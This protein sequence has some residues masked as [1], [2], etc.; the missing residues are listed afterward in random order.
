MTIL[1]LIFTVIYCL[2]VLFV[3][4]VFIK[5]QPLPPISVPRTISVVI[6]ARNE[7]SR[8]TATLQSL[9]KIN[10]PKDKYEIICVDDAST[11]KTAMLIE[12][13]ASL[14]NNWHLLKVS[15]KNGLKK[16]KKAAL[17]KG[18]EKAV[19]EIIL[20]TD[21]D[22]TVSENWLL[23]MNNCFDEKTNMVLG[24]S[25]LVK[26]KSW[27]NKLLRFDNLFSGIMVAAPALLGFPMSSIGRNIAYRK[28]TFN[29]IGGYKT[30]AHHKSGDDV[31]LTELFRKKVE[32]KTKFCF[33]KDSF[34]FS[35]IP[36]TFKEIF[37]QQIRKNSKLFKKSF[38]S[39]ALT[40][41]LLSYH[42]LLIIF[43]F[44][45]GISNF[46]ILLLA[47]KLGIEFTVLSISA[48]RFSE[49]RIIPLL[50][51]FQILYPAYV[52]LLAF[53]GIFQLYEWKK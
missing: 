28:S 25:V 6:A 15:Q 24:H 33:R 30:L 36:D 34:T 22:C 23:E 12:Q 52:S 40:L 31:H 9:Q 46:W 44:L 2:A 18:I 14:N 11:D 7:E 16:G 39:I 20:T 45:F 43:P 53:V 3:C 4:I 21:A 8:I 37:H 49:T 38:A 47:L 35:I 27:L 26:S 50:P 1:L 10:Y 13:A 41:F 19:G 17:E 32:G 42:L 5:V 29:T 48:V 51:F